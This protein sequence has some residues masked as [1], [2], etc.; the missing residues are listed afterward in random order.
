MAYGDY[1]GPDKPNKGRENGA[2]NRQLCQA[3][4]AIWCHH[5]NN[6]TWYCAD[7]RLAIEFDS[8]NKRDWAINWAPRYGPMFKT[9]E[10][11]D[12]EDLAKREVGTV[13]VPSSNSDS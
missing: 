1:H 13:Q 11:M 7:C 10:M 6:H 2:C 3:E 12:A 5:T 8:F 4:P 9:R